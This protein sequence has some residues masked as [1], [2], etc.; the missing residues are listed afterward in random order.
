MST[1]GFRNYFKP[2]VSRFYWARLW[3]F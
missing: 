3:C 2:L 1:Q